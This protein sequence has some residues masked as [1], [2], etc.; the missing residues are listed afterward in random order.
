MPPTPAKSAEQSL[1]AG[2]IQRNA[3]AERMVQN[4]RLAVQKA[5]QD[6]VDA[7][8]QGNPNSI[9]L[10]LK[11]D[12]TVETGVLP[13]H[14]SSEDVSII[15]E[16]PISSYEE[17]KGGR[18]LSR[19]ADGSTVRANGCIA[20]PMTKEELDSKINEN[21][22]HMTKIN[23]ESQKAIVE[24]LYD[25]TPTLTEKI[26]ALLPKHKQAHQSEAI[27]R[28]IT[29]EQVEQEF[30]LEALRFIRDTLVVDILTSDSMFATLTPARI[31][32]SSVLVH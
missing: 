15:N 29:L 18:H 26:K 31:Q 13:R 4:Q 5:I 1:C 24:A 19:R 30:V 2:V 25:M 32:S 12:S 20:S 23:Q 9:E 6:S 16:H 28:G 10:T 21:I 22:L 7:I 17:Q 11:L 14:L 8:A 27:S 3:E